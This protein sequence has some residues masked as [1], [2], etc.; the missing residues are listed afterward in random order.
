MKIG[1]MVNIYDDLWII[2]E[3]L[4]TIPEIYIGQTFNGQRIQF[5]VDDLDYGGDYEAV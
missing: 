2:I 4:E 3:V 1:E 5:T